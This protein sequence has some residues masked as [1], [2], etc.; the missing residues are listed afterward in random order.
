M[1]DEN[2]IEKDFEDTVTV[3]NSKIKEAATAMAEANAIAKKANLLTLTSAN[4]YEDFT[5]NLRSKKSDN[6][7]TEE[8]EEALELEWEKFSDKISKIDFSPLLNELS[9]AGWSTS[10]M[11]C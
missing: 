9:N 6:D 3:V 11:F 10:S 2:K 8:D 5:Y 1:V 4:A 7:W